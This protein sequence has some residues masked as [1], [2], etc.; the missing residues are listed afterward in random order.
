VLSGE[1]NRSIL[2]SAPDAMLIVD[3]AGTILFANA[4]VSALFGY[5][6]AEI[7]GRPVEMLLPERYR[8]RHVPHR[9][10]YGASMGVRP[11][12]S[13]LPL[14]ARRKD[15]DEFPVEISLSPVGGEA[16]PL[17]AAAIRDVTERK[18]TEAALVAA[19]E[20]ADRANQAKSRFLAAASHD[21]RQPLQTLAMLNGSLL[22]TVRDPRAR[23][24]LDLQDQAISAM[25]R[26][27]NSLLDISKLES[28]AIS[29]EVTDFRVAALFDELGREFASL[30]AS[31]GL[32]LRVDNCAD[33]VH[34]DPAL[35]GQI[36][37]NLLSNA[38]KYTREGWV[39]LRCQHLEALVR[40]EVLDTGIGIPADQIARIFDEFYQVGVSPNATR[41][42]Y[43]L[44]LS[45]VDRLVRLLGAR[46]DVESEP[47]KGSRF[48]LDLPAGETSGG[49]ADE[50][51]R[52]G[53]SARRAVVRL[54]LVEDDA[55]VRAAT[56]MLLRLEG[57]EVLAAGSVREALDLAARPESH[58]DL[59][60]TDY[61]LGDGETGLQVL[62]AL[63]DA[64]GRTLSA[65]L[66]TGDTSSAVRELGADPSLRVVSKP[67]DADQLVALL[68][69][70]AT[71]VSP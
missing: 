23:E 6:L 61:H 58:P 3:A 59:V 24:A 41:E 53:T 28:G 45:I 30:A 15:G 10:R 51:G 68:R 43:G 5:E 12:G 56:A 13:G 37:K 25:S 9:E 40:L 65:V 38:I 55:G 64:C 60:V 44:G 50:V 70:M 1:L 31:K 66:I 42:G 20:E 27:L 11:M 8:V 36:L 7:A 21:L 33:L 34:S 39:Q 17:V 19:R 16:T 63:R 4:Q 52:K 46:L 71:A 29:P 49:E 69:E 62:E 26:L 22:R 47:G 57:Y 18:R 48:A 32:E 14:F 35:V 2:E 54:L 67:I